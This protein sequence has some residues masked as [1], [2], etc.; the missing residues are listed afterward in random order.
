MKQ[1][2]QT[3][4]PALHHAGEKQTAVVPPTIGDN[5]VAA[6]WGASVDLAVRGT[7]SRQLRDDGGQCPAPGAG[8]PDG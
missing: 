6:A 4:D 2:M 3:Y 5:A 7:A 8:R 1:H